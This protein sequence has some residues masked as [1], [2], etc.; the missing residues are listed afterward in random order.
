MTTE[1]PSSPARD[2][3]SGILEPVRADLEAVE[4]VMDEILR[5]PSPAVRPLL[6]QV[7]RFRGKRLRPALCLL[8]GRCFGPVGDVHHKLGAVVE[9]IHTAT[10]VHDDVLDSADRRRGSETVN[11]RWGNKTAIL[12]GDYIF[13]SAFALSA[14]LRN[15]L[16]SRYLSWITGIVCQGEI[17]QI[18]QS[19]NLDIEEEVYFDVIEKK[20]AFLFSAAARV[21]ADYQEAGED[22]VRALAD[23]GMRLGTA[24][25]IVDDCLDLDGDEASV[26]KSL[27][28]DA[29]QGKATLPVI[30]FLRTA[31]PDARERLRSLIR[32]YA[33]HGARDELRVLLTESGS[34]AYAR[35]RAGALVEEAIRSLRFVPEG[36]ARDVLERLARYSLERT[37]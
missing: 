3:L 31:E 13:S 25:Q 19:G 10:L 17:L 33:E 28:T 1:T 36:P 9:L 15:P 24:F 18:L 5:P 6:E 11:R 27:G 8:A 21:G 26:G 37:R 29:L 35:G 20:T 2:A 22:A 34:L 4:A 12:L 23:Y 30:H 14:G 32:G 16:A 7:G